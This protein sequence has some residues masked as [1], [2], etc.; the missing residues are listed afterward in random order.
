M[1]GRDARIR[2]SAVPAR[3][4]HRGDRA[5][6]STCL[7]AAGERVP[8]ITGQTWPWVSTQ[9]GHRPGPVVGNQPRLLRGSS[10]S[11]TGERA[12]FVVEVG[13]VGV[14]AVDGHLGRRM[15]VYQ[16]MNG[17]IEADQHG[18][19]LRRQTDLCIETR[20]QALATPTSRRG[21]G[22]HARPTPTVNNPPPGPRHLGIDRRAG[23]EPQV[24]FRV[25]QRET[26]RPGSCPV[27]QFL[28][29]R[30]LA[31]PKVTEGEDI[32]A[33]LGEWNPKHLLCNQRRQTKLQTL[34]TL[35]AHL[36][37]GEIEPGY[38]GCRPQPSCHTIGIERP[39]I[40][41]DD[42]GDCRMRDSTQ[43]GLM[44]AANTKPSHIYVRQDWHPHRPHDIPASGD[45]YHR[46][47]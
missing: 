38:Q 36:E 29:S 27:L 43:L 41:T 13:L 23:Q 21:E 37:R 2:Q 9:V 20:G 12:N 7:H 18:R 31:A 14:T 3:S 17:L 6:S 44:L 34:H 42:H 30:S 16:A 26:I 24:Q 35:C 10:R 11:Y 46:R 33:Q 4:L 28:H 39:A 5:T 19:A 1:T 15:P 22:T 45:I 25:D 47:N 40:E 8:E 32:T